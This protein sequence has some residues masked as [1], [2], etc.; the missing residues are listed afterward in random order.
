M[1]WAFSQVRNDS[2]FPHRPFCALH[3]TMWLVN[4]SIH[5]DDDYIITLLTNPIQQ[6]NKQT[7]V[8]EWQSTIEHESNACET[9]IATT[10]GWWTQLLVIIES[11]ASTLPTQDTNK[12]RKK[13]F[14]IWHT[15]NGTH[16]LAHTVRWVAG[17][18]KPNCSTQITI[19]WSHRCTGWHMS[20]NR[21][22]EHAISTC[23]RVRLLISVACECVNTDNRT[24]RL[25]LDNTSVTSCRT[26]RG[27]PK[28]LWKRRRR[29][30]GRWKQCLFIFVSMCQS[31]ISNWILSFSVF[32]SFFNKFKLKIHT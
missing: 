3:V 18:N 13:T 27:I 6:I 16:T 1:H 24:N 15:I 25:M 29:R 17:E 19:M 2:S 4:R 12:Q 8:I 5:S 28:L 22:N 32:I 14:R 30:R 31:L 26:N 20:L 9:R 23:I 7:N 11:S 10:L 21:P